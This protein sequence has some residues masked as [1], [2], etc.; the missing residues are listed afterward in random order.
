[1]E[2][3]A[4]DALNFRTKSGVTA[5]RNNKGVV[6]SPKKNINSL[7]EAGEPAFSDA[8]IAMYTIPQ[9]NNPCKVPANKPP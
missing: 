6:P 5:A 1:M 3:I 9:G 2:T 7:P 8:A 4:A